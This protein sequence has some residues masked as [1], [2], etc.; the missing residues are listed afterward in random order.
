MISGYRLLSR[1]RLVMSSGLSRLCGLSLR[2][3]WVR[4]KKRRV[5]RAS[6]RLVRRVKGRDIL[7]SKKR[8]RRRSSKLGY[9]G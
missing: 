6:G 2:I 8:M 3:L 1:D 9:L 5:G 7:L 4:M